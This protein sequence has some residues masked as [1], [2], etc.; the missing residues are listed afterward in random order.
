MKETVR[1]LRWYF[2]ITGTLGVVGHVVVAPIE[3]AQPAL[4]PVLNWFISGALSAMTLYSAFNLPKLLQTR[5][6]L[7]VSANRLCQV[8]WI[9]SFLVAISGRLS[10]A[11]VW[12]H[13][14][15]YALGLV[16][17]RY[18]KRNLMRLAAESASVAGSLST[19]PECGET[20]GNWRTSCECGHRLAPADDLAG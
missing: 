6:G 12:A 10:A 19:C 8:W 11:Q 5:L 2:G 17:L 3:F 13:C 18:L 20:A 4:W 9:A 7:L 14:L 16:L 15:V 1:S